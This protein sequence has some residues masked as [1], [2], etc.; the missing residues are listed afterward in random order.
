MKRE[1]G[2]SHSAK[3][4]F[5]SSGELKFITELGRSLLFAVHPKKV[6]SRAAEVLRGEIGAEI[7]AVVVELENIGLI[8]C[9][10]AQNNVELADEFLYKNRLKKWLDFLPPQ[11]SVWTENESEFLLKNAKHG[12][13][14]VSP[15]HINGEVKGAVIAGFKGARECSDASKYLINAATQMAAMSVNLSAHYEARINTSINRA[16]EEHRRFTE[17]VLDAMPV[18][19]YV[20]DR[21]YRI[22]TW[23]KHREIGVQGIPRESVIGRD[24]FEVLA[25]FPHGKL[26]QEFE[27]AF[28][29]GKIERIEQRTTDA[30]GATKHWMVSKIPMRDKETG[31]ITHVITVGEDITARVEAIHAINRAEKLAAVGRLAAGVVHEINNPLAT[32]SAC[33]ESLESRVSEGVFGESD[34]VDDLREYLGLIR[35][36]AFRCKSITNNLLDFSRYRTGNRFS[37]DISEVVK[38]SARLVSHQK[39]GENINFQIETEANLPLVEADEGQIQQAIIALATNAIDAMPNG[40]T[41]TFRAFSQN[42]RVLIEVQD[43]GIGIAPEDVSKIFEPFFTTKEVGKGTGL[44]LAVCYGIITEHGGNLSVRSNPGVETT[45]TIYLPSKSG[46]SE[47]VEESES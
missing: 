28:K 33:A 6:A 17:A 41:L 32:I 25:K 4:N 22:V 29:T 36:E 2:L 8:S 5:D 31:Q 43:T 40:G 44:G 34:E 20:I 13:E 35:G 47:K 18:S 1:K 16:K 23:N 15:L 7:C 14:Y 19:I 21:A 45:F 9:A 30:E 24:I 27:R 3:R 37:I 10:F 46:K 42:S 11:I 38:S 39:R 26:R 12:Y